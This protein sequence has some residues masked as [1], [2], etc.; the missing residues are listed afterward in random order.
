MKTGVAVWKAAQE[1]SEMR[2]AKCTHPAT[3]P[4]SPLKMS[5]FLSGAAGIQSQEQEQMQAYVQT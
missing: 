5:P 1:S 4:A 2:Q 3:S